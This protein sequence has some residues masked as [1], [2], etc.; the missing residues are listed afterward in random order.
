MLQQEACRVHA[1][2]VY[3]PACGHGKQAAEAF[4]ELLWAQGGPAGQLPDGKALVQVIQYMRFYGIYSLLF[5]GCQEFGAQGSV[6]SAAENR[7]TAKQEQ[8][9]FPGLEKGFPC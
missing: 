3:V 6:F 1:A 8:G 4:A 7:F 9:G 2:L 5:V